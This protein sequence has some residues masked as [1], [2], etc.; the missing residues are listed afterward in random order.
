MFGFDN[1]SISGGN[2]V[3]ISY[4]M[5][6]ANL[7]DLLFSSLKVLILVPHLIDNHCQLPCP[8][9]LQEEKIMVEEQ[10][11]TMAASIGTMEGVGI[12]A[13][14]VFE[15]A[16]FKQIGHLKA[17]NGDDVKLQAAQNKLVPTPLLG[18]PSHSPLFRKWTKSDKML[19]IETQ[20]FMCLV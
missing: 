14:E 19:R 6:F 7:P 12:A 2:T 15:T 3:K 4:S 10:E 9:Q 18:N 17:F 11:V 20:N 16:G 5:V 1:D 8:R 13:L